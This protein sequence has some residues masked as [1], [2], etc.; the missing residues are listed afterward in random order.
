MGRDEAETFLSYASRPLY[1]GLSWYP[2]PNNHLFYTLLLH[3]AWRMFG[4]QEW[5]IRLPALLG[6]TLLIPV[7]YWA[8]RVLYDSH[9]ALIAA[10]IVAASSPLIAYSVAGRGYTLLCVFAL[11]L[12][13]TGQY[14]LRH[15]SPPG[16]LVW[17]LVGALGFY[18]I[19]VM[20]YAV[21]MVA[22]WLV[23]SSREVEPDSR[24]RLSLVHL[25]LALSFMGAVTTFLYLPVLVVSG[26]Q[27]LLSNPVVQAK[28]LTYL[29]AALPTNIS[30][31]WDQWTADVPAP[32]VWVL[33]LGF[34][35]TLLFHRR[36]SKDGIP[37]LLVAAIFIP[38]LLLIQ[39]VVPFPRVWLFLLPLFA[40][41]SSA[42]IW[43]LVRRFG[44][45]NET[46]SSRLS[47]VMA[48]ACFVLMCHYDLR[49]KAL[50][51]FGQIRMDRVAAWMKQSVLP[52]DVIAVKPGWYWSP[53]SYYLRRQGIPLISR[54]AP[55]DPMSMVYTFKGEPMGRTTRETRVLTVARW[56]QDLEEVLSVACVAGEQYPSPH[57][58]YEDA[59][60]RVYESR[61]GPGTD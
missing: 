31:S 46:Y 10:S 17:T 13:I 56:D 1:V 24:H 37:V 28:S 58:I 30:L 5:V 26:W 33:L 23:L 61:F 29:F 34:A 38:L 27:A 45:R 12:L 59:G 19:P 52:G 47:V 15:D 8:A 50:G 18:T 53:L 51:T 14:L 25:S 32:L 4:E 35:A 54:A 16:W 60:I 40:A 43:L 21:G 11:L 44:E 39:R 9:S 55:C 22:M 7:T 41:A 42:G 36:T 49:D 20:L 57:L 6:G 3:F 2:A 48:L